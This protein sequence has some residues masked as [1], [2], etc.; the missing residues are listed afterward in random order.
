MEELRDTYASDSLVMLAKS[1]GFSGEPAHVDLATDREQYTPALI[2]KWIIYQHGLFVEIRPVM[3]YQWTFNIKGVGVY[4]ATSKNYSS[5]DDAL[6]NGLREACIM[7]KE[8]ENASR[9]LE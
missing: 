3:E 1:L 2:H 9:I 5:Y 6:E 4:V 8:K 7:L